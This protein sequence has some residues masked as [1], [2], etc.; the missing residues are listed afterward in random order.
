MLVGMLVSFGAI[1]NDTVV[2]MYTGVD[3]AMIPALAT[4]VPGTSSALV[5][6]PIVFAVII[7]VSIL[8]DDPPRDVKRL[9]RQCHSPEPMQ[10]METAEDVATDGGTTDE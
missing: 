9:V 5:G 1:V 4:W 7:V 3:E 8:T 6:V 2:P 10:Q